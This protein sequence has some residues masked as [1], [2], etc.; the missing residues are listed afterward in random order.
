M[1]KMFQTKIK[2][3]DIVY[4]KWGELSQIF[5]EKGAFCFNKRAPLFYKRAFGWPRMA[6][7]G[8]I[9]LIRSY[10][11]HFWFKLRQNNFSGKGHFLR[12]RPIPKHFLFLKYALVLI[13]LFIVF[14]KL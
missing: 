10:F 2:N 6:G 8:Q 12:K 1:L 7:M 3:E 5:L 11:W 13:M 9:Y 14:N 4:L